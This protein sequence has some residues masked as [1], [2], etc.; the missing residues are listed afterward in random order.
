MSVVLEGISWSTLTSESAALL[1]APSIDALLLHSNDWP[2]PSDAPV[3]SPL[4]SFHSKLDKQMQLSDPH[5]QQH[6]DL[7]FK[8]NDV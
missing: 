3:S 5:R 4:L 1:S 6:P 7:F 8:T 2:T